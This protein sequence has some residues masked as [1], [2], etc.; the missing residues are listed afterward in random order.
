LKRAAA[1]RPRAV[2]RS[3]A[4]LAR[5]GFRACPGIPSPVPCPGWPPGADRLDD[6]PGGPLGV[7]RHQRQAGA[8]REPGELL[9]GLPG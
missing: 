7:H 1:A 6:L 5:T 3:K 2:R 9:P 4:L 8:E